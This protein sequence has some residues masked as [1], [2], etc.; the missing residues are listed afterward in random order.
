MTRHL[1]PRRIRSRIGRHGDRCGAENDSSQKSPS[2][3]LM[4]LETPVAG[5]F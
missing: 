4:L 2:Y 5:L 1:V 3:D